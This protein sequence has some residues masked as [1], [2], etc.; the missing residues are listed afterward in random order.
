MIPGRYWIAAVLLLVGM[1]ALNVPNLVG[2]SP[3]VDE[4]A[5]VPAGYSYLH[6]GDYRLYSK[7]PPLI[8]MIC[9]MPLAGMKLNFPLREWLDSK[10]AWGPWYFADAFAGANRDKM[11]RVYAYARVMNMLLAAALGLVVFLWASSAYGPRAAL[12]AMAF[13]VTS[14]TVLAHAGVATVDVGFTLFFV[15]ALF[16]FMKCSEFPTYGRLLAAGACF[17]AAQ[18][19]KFSGVLLAPILIVS[20]IV[21]IVFMAIAWKRKEDKPKTSFRKVLWVEILCLLIVFFIGLV[22]INAGYLFRGSFSRLEDSVSAGEMMKSVTR[23]PIAQVPMPLPAEYLRGLDLQLADTERGEFPNYLNGKWRRKGAW[24]YFLE[25]TALKETLPGLIFII[26]G[27]VLSLFRVLRKRHNERPRSRFPVWPFVHL[28]TIIFLVAISFTGNLQL[29]V[30]YALPILPLA[31]IAASAGFVG[32]EIPQSVTEY[33]GGRKFGVVKSVPEELFAPG[34]RIKRVVLFWLVVALFCWQCIA[35]LISA[36]H[37]LSY[38][39]TI[40]G[41]TEG[42]PRYLLDSNVD[43]GQDL[44]S[45]AK[46]MKELESK[47]WA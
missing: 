13:T 21:L 2:Q 45:L 22:A 29:G 9:A 26:T 19:S 5:H 41:G 47:K 20:T 25:A 14:P 10:G 43:W 27:L 4:Y 30:R 37:Y 18:L 11:R 39:N 8:K 17:G 35:V 42:G 34:E 40:A 15:L 46:K 3:T 44:P 24:Y 28:P 16:T 33:K 6:K 1:V 31:F 38:F 7:N 36:P 23:S 32:R 12:A